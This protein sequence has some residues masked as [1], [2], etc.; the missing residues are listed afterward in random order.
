MKLIL[1]ILFIIGLF[2]LTATPKELIGTQ[3]NKY[4]WDCVKTGHATGV[5]VGTNGQAVVSSHSY[6]AVSKCFYFKI[7]R[8]RWFDDKKRLELVDDKFCVESD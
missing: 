3:Y 8:Q 7:T 5:G 2:W 4:D 6:C 1:V